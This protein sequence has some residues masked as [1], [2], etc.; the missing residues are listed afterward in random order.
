MYCEL[1]RIVDKGV[2]AD[3]VT[4]LT[5]AWKDLKKRRKVLKIVIFLHCEISG[6]HGGEDDDVVL[7]GGEDGLMSRKHVAQ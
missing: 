2:I 1:E 5:F 7:L 6:S 3:L 4:I